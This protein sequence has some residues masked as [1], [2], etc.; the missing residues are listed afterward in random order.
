MS[1]D[2]LKTTAGGEEIGLPASAH[3]GGI[4][5]CEFS[6]GERSIYKVSGS[7]NDIV[8]EIGFYGVSQ[9][10]GWNIC[11]QTEAVNLGK[12]DGTSQ[13]F[14]EGKEPLYCDVSE[15]GDCI[16]I[17]EKHFND[18]AEIFVMDAIV[19]NPDR[20]FQ[21]VKINE[22][23]KCWA[24]DNDMWAE[25]TYMQNHPKRIHDIL[26]N[27]QA[28][29]GDD[30]VGHFDA[31]TDWLNYSLDEDGYKKFRGVVNEK[32]AEILKHKDEIPSHYVYKGEQ[33]RMDIIDTYI[34]GAEKYMLSEQKK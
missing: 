31:F 20:H 18:L 7:I 13:A 29:S 4:H 22:D 9:S 3:S 1:K 25:N 15:A 33:Y 6:G 26:E 16:K 2:N 5:L 17:E 11:P 14:A 28:K 27:L 8:G 12:G 10:L 23:G 24:I 30:K 32:M 21:N 19:G 34:E